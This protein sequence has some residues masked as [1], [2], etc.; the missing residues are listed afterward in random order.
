MNIHLVSKP[1]RT[2]PRIRH[3]YDLI[4]KSDYRPLYNEETNLDKKEASVDSNT[5]QSFSP[6][7]DDSACISQG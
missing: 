1:D 6:H 7:T 5:P 4:S 2:R 3:L